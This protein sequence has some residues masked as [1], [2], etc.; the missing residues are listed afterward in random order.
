MSG[1]GLPATEPH[2]MLSDSEFEDADAD[3]EAQFRVLDAQSPH[4]HGSMANSRR[5]LSL[6]LNDASNLSQFSGFS[7]SDFSSHSLDVAA[8]G[9]IEASSIRED[10]DAGSSA[11]LEADRQME[12]F[13]HE[14]ESFWLNDPRF[15]RGIGGPESQFVSCHILSHAF[16]GH[17]SHFLVRCLGFELPIWVPEE[18]LSEIEPFGFLVPLCNALL[19]STTRLRSNRFH[20]FS[21]R[22]LNPRL[23]LQPH[24]LVRYRRRLRVLFLLGVFSRRE[25]VFRTRKYVIGVGAARGRGGD[26]RFSVSQIPWQGIHHLLR[27]LWQAA[28][29]HLCWTTVL[30]L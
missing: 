17:G 10:E 16:R 4:V 12:T 19:V 22:C 14:M 24:W 28:L 21:P 20:L 26:D 15:N 25:C 2:A 29:L 27:H 30:R 1:A 13:S 6:P 7:I 3:L 11:S 18:A 9:A 5:N 8:A 23:A